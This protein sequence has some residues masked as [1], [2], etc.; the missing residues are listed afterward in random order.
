MVSSHT[1]QTQ[2]DQN[3]SRDEST[4]SKFVRKPRPAMIWV[5]EPDGDRTRLVARWTTQ[6]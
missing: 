6:D 5:M 2:F 4:A 1:S 3:D